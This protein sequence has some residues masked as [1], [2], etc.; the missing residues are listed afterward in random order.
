MKEHNTLTF[1][2]QMITP[3]THFTGKKIFEDIY[4][5]LDSNSA[6]LSVGNSMTVWNLPCK[7]AGPSPTSIYLLSAVTGELIW[8]CVRAWASSN[9]SSLVEGEGTSSDLGRDKELWPAEAETKNRNITLLSNSV[10]RLKIWRIISV[11]T[12][13]FSD[14]WTK[15]RAEENVHMVQDEFD[16]NWLYS[17]LHEG[18]CSTEA[19]RLNL[20]RPNYK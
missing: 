10:I 11:H 5:Y 6:Y 13:S 16:H 15:F 14:Q 19:C 18:S 8:A 9:V 20:L 2:K 12:S 7:A 4:F 3:R 1:S 17:Y